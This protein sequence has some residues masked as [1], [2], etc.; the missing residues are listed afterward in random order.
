MLVRVR[1]AARC[2]PLAR[3]Q[4]MR[5]AEALRAS[6][7]NVS[8]QFL[9]RTTSGDRVKTQALSELGGKGLYI[10]ELEEAV[11]KGEADAAVHSVKDMPAELAEGL[12]LA[13]VSERAESRDAM[14]P[15]EAGMRMA[16]LPAGA[17]VGTSSVRRSCQ[18]R[19]K[20]PQLS[21]VPVR[22]NVDTRLAKL[23][24]NEYDALIL[25]AAGLIR[26]GHQARISEYIDTSL[27]VPAAGQGAIGVETR[28]DC[29]ELM[30]LFRSIEDADAGLCVR[31]ERLVCAQL[32]SS[33]Y[34]ALGVYA[35]RVAE[36][37]NNRRVRLC[38][39]VANPKGKE[40]LRVEESDSD[41]R[42]ETLA[43]RVSNQL[44]DG[45][46]SQWLGH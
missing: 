38:A 33:C 42:V 37:H 5:V 11:L 35:S 41:N 26:L 2:S 25:A 7:A 16:D 39:A 1:L 12:V 4:A 24:A 3:Y 45:G 17:R 30:P 32:Q 46:A 29:G 23:D 40:L 6:D 22:G 28:V 43:R 21:F 10:A 44:L 20:Y 9:W 15:Q 14:V 36:S 34:S 31:T 8:V 18:L 19:A 13:A 27:C